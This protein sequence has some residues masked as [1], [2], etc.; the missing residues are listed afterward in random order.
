MP[1][2]SATVRPYNTTVGTLDDGTMYVQLYRTI[3]ATWGETTVTY[4]TGG[5]TT[6]TTVRRMEEAARQF[7]LPMPPSLAEWRRMKEDSI[8]IARR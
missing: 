2:C 4:R 3:I 7:G 6:T 8:T 5:W 1:R